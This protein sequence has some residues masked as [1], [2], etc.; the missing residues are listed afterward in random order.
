MPARA[1]Q[2][3]RD[4]I[5]AQAAALGLVIEEGEMDGLAGR[6]RSAAEDVEKMDGLGIE[7]REPAVKFRARAERS[8]L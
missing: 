5:L 6:V 8:G 7:G 2:V 3:T 1:R 4:S